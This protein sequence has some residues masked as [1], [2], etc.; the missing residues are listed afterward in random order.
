MDR[1]PELIDQISKD[2]EIVALFAFGSLARGDLK[3][4]SDLDFGIFA[5]PTLDR[6]Q[7]F[8]KHLELIGVFNEHFETDEIDL[9]LMN[10]VRAGYFHKLMNYVRAKK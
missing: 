5:I 9:V 8:D 7:R 6:K 1:L 2:K 4:L 3:P 10:D